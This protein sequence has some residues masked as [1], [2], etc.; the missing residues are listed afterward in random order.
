MKD[1][2]QGRSATYID[3]PKG[4]FTSNGTWFRVTEDSL[5]EYAGELLEHES[6]GRTHIKSRTMATYTSK[7]CVMAYSSLALAA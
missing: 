6:L 5:K 4:I 3:T 2:A 1:T 7:L